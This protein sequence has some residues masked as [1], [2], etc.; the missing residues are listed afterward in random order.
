[1]RR[2]LGR[3]VGAPLAEEVLATY[4]L[5]YEL[6]MLVEL[7]DGLGV[8]HDEGRLAH[9][10]PTSPEPKALEKAVAGFRKGADGQKRELLLRAFAAQASVEWPGLEALLG[11]KSPAPAAK[12]A[13]PKAES[14]KAPRKPRAKAKTKTKAKKKAKARAKKKKK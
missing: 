3:T 7:L 11:E 2:A 5:E 6:E 8:D 13:A 14:K 1:M 4:F 9:A 10:S 12:A